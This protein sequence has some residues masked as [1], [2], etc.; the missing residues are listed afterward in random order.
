MKHHNHFCSAQK[1]TC[2][3]EAQTNNLDV[4]STH[5]ISIQKKVVFVRLKLMTFTLQQD[6]LPL[7]NCPRT[8]GGQGAQ[9]FKNGQMDILRT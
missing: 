2:L 6:A 3:C 9:N 5:A 8:V 7:R 1:R 4:I